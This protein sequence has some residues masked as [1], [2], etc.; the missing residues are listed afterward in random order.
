VAERGGGLI[1][2]ISRIVASTLVCLCVHE[3]REKTDK[4]VDDTADNEKR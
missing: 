3:S 2:Y 4:V 1:L